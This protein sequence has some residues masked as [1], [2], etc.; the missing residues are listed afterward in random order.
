MI[1][2]S[3]SPLSPSSV[4]FF[5]VSSGCIATGRPRS[6]IAG[7]PAESTKWNN[8]DFNLRKE[9]RAL[10]ENCFVVVYVDLQ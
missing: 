10:Q 5:V 1:G 4:A 9:D 6:E 8:R 3:L 7:N 2:K